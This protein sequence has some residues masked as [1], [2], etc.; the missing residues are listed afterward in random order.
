MSEKIIDIF[1]IDSSQNKQANKSQN[2]DK[3]EEENTILYNQDRIQTKLSLRKKKI[4][5]I[6]S[7]KRNIN[8]MDTFQAFNTSINSDFISSE[9]EIIPYS[10]S[11]FTSGDLYIKLKAYFESK[12]I[13][14][15]RE[16]IN[17]LVIFFNEKKL[18]SIEM[19]ELYMKSGINVNNK[20]KFP[21]AN[22]LFNIGVNTEDKII[23]V[24]CFNFMLNFSF[25][26]DEFCKSLVE[27]KKNRFNFGKIKLF[28]SD[29]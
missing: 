27:E 10:K 13:D 25:I 4:E 26:S 12:D 19:K 16:I 24:Y 2:S 22:L 17:N 15:I 9:H 20:E 5:E 23:Y 11:D 14:N 28:L 3:N 1:K 6:L 18:D 7:A 29:F 8:I 21:F